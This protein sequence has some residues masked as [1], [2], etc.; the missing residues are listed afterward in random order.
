MSKLGVVETLKAAKARIEEEEHWNKG[1]YAVDGDGMRCGPTSYRA[2]AYCAVGA[3]CAETKRGG[4][5]VRFHPAYEFL[6]R[7][8][9]GGFIT[10]FNDSKTHSEVL[11]AFDEAIRAASEASHV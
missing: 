3:L 7:A 6:G 5:R 8:V 1:E 11:A 2:Y 9:P 10:D 4:A